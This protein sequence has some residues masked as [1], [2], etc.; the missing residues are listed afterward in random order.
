MSE[1]GWTKGPWNFDGNCGGYISEG[2]DRIARVYAHNDAHLVAAAPDLAAVAMAYE[3]WEADLILDHNAWNHEL[4]YLTQGLWDRLLEIQA[5]RNA[6]LS[7]ARGEQS[8]G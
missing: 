4:P 3:Q 6:A 8:N 2:G 5:M 7:R 1:P